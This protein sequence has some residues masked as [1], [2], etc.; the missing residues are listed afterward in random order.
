MKK[1]DLNTNYELN[2]NFFANV[3]TEEKA[4]LLGW[5]AGVR[6]I[7]DK[8]IT[9]ITSLNIIDDY[10]KLLK[11]ESNKENDDI[12]LPELSE[13]LTWDFIRGY[14]DGCGNIHKINE[15]N[16]TPSCDI[17]SNSINMLNDI[18]EFCKIPGSI[19]NNTIKWRSNN[20]LDFLNNIYN[21]S[22]I[23]LK[24]KYDQYLEI[25]TWVPS[26]SYSRY[27]KNDHCSWS[28]TR[29]DA[30]S[31]SKQRA[32]D[33]GYDLVLLEKIK[34]IGKVEFYDTGI[35]VKPNFGYY[36]T[37][38]PRSSISKTGYML[39]NSI[40]I[41]DRTYLGNIIVAL[42]KIDENMPDLELPCRLVQI[43][44]NHIVHFEMNEVDSFDINETE[45][46]ENGFGSPEKIKKQ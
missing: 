44:P 34:T 41:I 13:K 4:Y 10:Y 25:S 28:K 46:G 17:K 22:K 45:R 15:S 33:S 9:S 8:F 29:K 36:F 6:N 18:N 5:I 19:H 3:D 12:R 37:L 31:P 24:E 40:G 21:N 30:I 16:S 38:V 11:I 1:N 14:F 26:V 42:I 2:D 39:A 43:I 27:Y 20:A 32:S 35:K 7:N 23:K